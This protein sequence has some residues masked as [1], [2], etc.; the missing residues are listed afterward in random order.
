MIKPVGLIV[1]DGW[2]LAPPGPGNP[3]G[4]A[5]VPNFKRYWSL[6]PHCKLTASGEAV[7]LPRGEDGNTE[8]GHLN[9]GAGRIVYQ[10]LP[11]INL[12]IADG[13]FFENKAFLDAIDHV[14]HHDSKLHLLGLIGS[15]GVHSNIEHLYALI[16]LCKEQSIDKVFIHVIT[17]GRDSPP[18]SALEYTQRLEDELKKLKLG[19]V[20]SISGRYYAMDRDRRWDRTEK[21]YNALTKGMGEHA[22]S[23]EEAIRNAYAQ[24]ETDEFISPTLIMENNQPVAKIED[25]DA[26]IFFN[27]RI[28][29]PRQLTQSFVLD[30]L[31]KN[32]NMASF[33]PYTVK[34]Y[35]RHQVEDEGLSQYPVFKR[36]P[37]LKNLVFVTMTRYEDNSPAIP[38]FPPQQVDYPLG[39]IIDE[40]GLQQLHVSETEKERF[41]TYY[42]NGL[43]QTPFTLEE[44]LIIPSPKV[45]TYDLKPEM[46]ALEM[47][48]QLLSKI[49]LGV[50]SFFVVNYA[51]PDMVAHT[52]VISQAIKALEVTDECLGKI[53]RAIL[54]MGGSCVITADH[55]N[56]E[57]MIDPATGGTDTEHSTNPVPCIII[58][59]DLEGRNTEVDSGILADVAPTILT[60]MNLPKPASMTGR[61]LISQKV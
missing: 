26:V 23:L 55:G 36:G 1:L 43:R 59:K 12:A 8:T 3:L 9:L 33:D 44:R 35:K 27:F 42:F 51:N 37:K 40:H 47:T 61:S 7:G 2:G 54:T 53:V 31:E 19:R 6:Y 29:R 24:K 25:N 28:D 60:L 52:G 14:K 38:A 34:Y 46:S 4:F 58:S 15:G 45:P 20:A 10:D 16:H 56:V 39:R 11:R 41:V 30:D 5:N 22:D 18:A 50:Y 57:E 13:T 48:D 17:D 32:P 21:A 49:Q